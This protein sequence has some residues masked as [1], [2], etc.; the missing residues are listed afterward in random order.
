MITLQY[1]LGF[2]LLSGSTA[3]VCYLGTLTAVDDDDTVPV[4]MLLALTAEV[5][6][7]SWHVFFWE[8]PF[9]VFFLPP[10]PLGTRSLVVVVV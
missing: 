3:V 10:P 1:E 9:F 6:F 7:W 4:A 2:V 5:I 8:A